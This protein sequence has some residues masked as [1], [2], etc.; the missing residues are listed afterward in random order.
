MTLQLWWA[1]FFVERLLKWNSPE[2]QVCKNCIFVKSD[3][4]VRNNLCFLLPELCTWQELELAEPEVKPMCQS[5]RKCWFLWLL[6]LIQR[7]G[8]LEGVRQRYSDLFL[9]GTG[10]Y[11][12]RLAEGG[13]FHHTG[14]PCFHTVVHPHA[15]SEAREV[16][17]VLYSCREFGW[18]AERL[19]HIH[20]VTSNYLTV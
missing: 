7:R 17:W 4:S 9:S 12:K 19:R 5:Y 18:D 1:L 14:F 8:F 10:T 20:D 11:L 6:W 15:Q 2:N 16:V 3:S 13:R